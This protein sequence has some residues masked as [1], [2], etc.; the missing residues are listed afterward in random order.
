MIQSGP[1]SLDV[2]TRATRRADQKPERQDGDLGNTT[3]EI[4]NHG[5]SPVPPRRGCGWGRVSS[6]GVDSQHCPE[7]RRLPAS[8]RSA[9][10]RHF[11]WK[12][13]RGGSLRAFN[14]KFD[15]PV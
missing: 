6:L 13:T 10:S 14:P 15:L 4:G 9:T 5:R 12:G 11:A 8:L 3:V 2:K 7:L 1:L